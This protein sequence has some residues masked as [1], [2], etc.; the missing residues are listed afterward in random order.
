MRGLRRD[1]I[2][3]R[4]RGERASFGRWRG[5]G[6][7]CRRP[8][9]QPDR[10][11]HRPHRRDDRRCSRRSLRGT[12]HREECEEAHGVSRVVAHGRWFAAHSVAAR[13]ARLRGGRPRPRV[14]R[15]DYRKGVVPRDFYLCE[16]LLALRRLRGT[17]P[18][19]RRASESP[20]AIACL[21]LFTLLPE[22]PL[23]SFPCFRSCIARLTL[24]CAV[25]PYLAIWPPF[26]WLQKAHATSMP[27]E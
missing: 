17:L 4:R 1:R 5:G 23:R 15:Q 22:R 10:P 9:R 24:R 16:A 26:R 13:S 20:I 14:E 3:S 19:A 11:W 6:R 18:P 2:D 8:D 7:S 12:H 27:Q 25:L 21:R